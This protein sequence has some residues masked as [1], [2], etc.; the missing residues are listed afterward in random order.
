MSISRDTLGSRK[1]DELKENYEIK[2]GKRL[3]NKEIA[4][5]LNIS[6]AALCKRLNGD[7]L[8]RSDEIVA[9]AHF[10]GI[11][12]DELFTGVSAEN[13]QI[14]EEYGLNE[15]SLQWLK[16]SN[17]TNKKYIKL[18]NI[19]LND[20]N[21]ADVIFKAMLIY[22]NSVMLKLMPLTSKNLEEF[23]YINADT[24]DEIIKKIAVD[25]IVAG[26]QLVSDEWDKDNRIKLR[27][28]LKESS[29]PIKKK[30][31]LQTLNKCESETEKRHFM[32]NREKESKINII[33]ELK[34]ID[35]AISKYN[36][37]KNLLGS[38]TEFSP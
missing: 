15:K 24:S 33:D 9:M 7:V 27:N 20:K 11:S 5:E 14:N 37:L 1:L 21:I 18:L 35:N 23:I 2:Y 30:H 8:F 3:T 4:D 38:E 6:P 28:Q 36:E 19:I 31:K 25:K 34:N 12:C 22:C 10:F 32:K 16:E 17:I 29:L 26:L 13:H